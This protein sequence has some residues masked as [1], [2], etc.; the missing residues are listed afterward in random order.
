A[1]VSLNWSQILSNS[2]FSNTTLSYVNYKVKS[3]LS[4]TAGRSL[5][6]DYYSVSELHDFIVKKDVEFFISENNLGKLGINFSLHK[7]L[8]TYSDV[9]SD[10]IESGT[11][12]QKD[13]TNFEV[14]GFIQSEWQATPL[15]K[16]NTGG[17]IY[18]FHDQKLFKVEP[19]VS[20]VYNLSSDLSLKAAYSVANQFLHLVVKN[21]ISLP[22]DLWYPSTK[23][24]EPASA[25]QYVFGIDNFF[26]NHEYLLSVEGYYKGMKNLY[27]FRDN[28][29]YSPSNPVST[30]FTKGEGEA[31]GLELFLN[32]IS[33]DL[34]GW[35]GYTLSWTKR[36]FDDLNYGKIFY[37]RFDR[38]HDISLI[39]TYKLLDNF[40]LG[41]TWT[42][43][44]GQGFTVPVSQFQI[45]SIGP[46]P[47]NRIVFN[48]TERN[49]YKLP[50]YHKMDFNASYSFTW[51]RTTIETYLNIYNVY[52]RKNPF[53][54]IASIDEA[55][56]DVNGISQPK[57]NSISL[58]P[59]IP[60]IGIN[61]KL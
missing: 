7:Y 28:A 15:F 42:Y 40:T 53:A 35:I 22:T 5:S 49:T 57:F 38:R 37:P 13:I 43:A 52:N 19:R 8:L 50:D 17:R 29:R 2:R 54:Y 14:T 23:D 58:F 4:D 44:S 21:D 31:Y 25:V 3:I 61:F 1:T 20:A 16:F 30:L 48:Y 33:G 55:K 10:L 11:G 12:R 45:G 6:S 56:K 24:I 59:F 34:S 9:Y 39:L 18:Y 46:D 51:K 32:K 60:S 27:E 36:K 41:L 26:F 47:F